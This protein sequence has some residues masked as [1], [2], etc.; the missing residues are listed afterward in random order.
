[1]VEECSC[2]EE[3]GPLMVAGGVPWPKERLRREAR[4]WLKLV[5][6]DAVDVL[7]AVCGRKFG[8]IFEC[9]CLNSGV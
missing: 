4:R 5:P 8:G 6:V 2:V 3:S 1:M 7:V 9:G